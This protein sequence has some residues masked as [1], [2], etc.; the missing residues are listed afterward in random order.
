MKLLV[1]G[2]PTEVAVDDYIPYD[3]K[4]RHPIFAGKK[5]KNIWPIL[6]E[7]AWAKINGSYEDIVTGSSCESLRTLIP[8]PILKF[9][10]DNK[11]LDKDK[12]WF[13]IK[14]GLEFQYI[15]TV[16]S[17]AKEDSKLTEDLEDPETGIII[18][19]CYS[20][21]E[22][23][24]VTVNR[25]EEKLIRV[26]NPWGKQSYKGKWSDSDPNWTGRLKRTVKFSEKPKG[27]FFMSFK[28]FMKYFDS[29][30]I[31]K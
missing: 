1:N 14:D 27:D 26:S 21:K 3:T 18:N 23:F 6:L 5:T 16:S 8:Y 10:T 29:V 24:L 31:C 2:Y 13:D 28:D 25:K 19:H 4:S 12:L 30:T 20:I 9:R 22:T 11:D 7:K 17:N 15:I